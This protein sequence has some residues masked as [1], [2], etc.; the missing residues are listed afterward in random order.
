MSRT[1]TTLC[2]VLA[3]IAIATGS[4]QA[5]GLRGAYLEARTNDVFTGPCFSNAEVFITGHQAVVAWKVA[6]GS[7]RGVDLAGLSVAAAVRGTSTFSA[8]DPAEARSVLIVDRR[9][10]PAQRTALI[11]LARELGGERLNHVVAVKDAPLDLVVEPMSHDPASPEDPAHLAHAMPRSPLA[12]FWAPGIARISTR[13]LDD[14]DHKCGNEVVAYPPLSKGVTVSPAY[15]VGNSFQGDELGTR[16]D[17][18]N[19]RSSL[20]GHFAL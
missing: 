4:A 6:E 2:G 9:A 5:A 19:A 14:G 3:G 16:W 20:V 1:K 12:L 7:Y 10:T 17:D 18:P 13:P 8:D 11:A 15:T